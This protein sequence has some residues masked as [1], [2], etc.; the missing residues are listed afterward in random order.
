[1]ALRHKGLQAEE[2]PWRFTQKEAIAFSGQKLVRRCIHIA[3]LSVRF[4]ESWD[5]A[6]HLALSSALVAS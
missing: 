4:G 1:M 6:K 2:I 3:P 5:Y